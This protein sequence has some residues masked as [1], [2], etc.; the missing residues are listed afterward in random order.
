MKTWQRYLIVLVTLI[1]ASGLSY[2]Y[3]QYNHAHSSLSDISQVR[4]TV[5]GFGDEL[6]QVSLLAP[7]DAVAKAMNEHYSYYVH[8]D[9]LAKWEADPMHAPGRLTS[10]PWPDAIK[11]GTSTANADGTY[12][13]DASIIERTSASTTPAATIP[14]RFTLTKGP[15]GWQITGY[16]KL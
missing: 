16:E 3:Y 14:V 12:T 11:V 2:W 4:M 9:L 7:A 15:D 5:E 13:M 10:S 8:P 6:R 1:A